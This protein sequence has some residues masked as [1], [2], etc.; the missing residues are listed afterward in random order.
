MTTAE[1][2]IPV[3]P[4]NIRRDLRHVSGRIARATNH[5]VL[6]RVRPVVQTAALSARDALSRTGL[7]RADDGRRAPIWNSSNLLT[8]T[9]VALGA[10]VLVATA[11]RVRRS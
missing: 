3:Y 2:L 11:A 1:P 6:D 7:V 4:E 10:F 5:R 8:A 9:G